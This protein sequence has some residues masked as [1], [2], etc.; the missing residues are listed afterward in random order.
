M[1]WDKR[2]AFSVLLIGSAL[3]IYYTKAQ[4]QVSLTPNPSSLVFTAPIGKTSAP[5]TFTITN[6]TN[7]PQTI[8]SVKV[9]S[10]VDWYKVVGGTCSVNLVLAAGQTCTV[11]V[12][13]SMPAAA[14]TNFQLKTAQGETNV[15]QTGDTHLAAGGR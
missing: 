2:I 5:Q 4:T 9:A 12:T 3:F 10:G 15:P 14:P 1:T 8:T 13:F 7:I 6:T 11:Q